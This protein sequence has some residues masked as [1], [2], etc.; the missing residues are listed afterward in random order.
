M[1]TDEDAKLVTLARQARARIQAADGA[2]VRDEMGRS[3]S[4]ATIDL[5]GLQVSALALAV[6]QAAAAGAQSIEAAVVVTSEGAPDAG[7]L[8]HLIAP[9]G[10]L[11]TCSPS[12]EVLRSDV[13][14][15]DGIG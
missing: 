9:G 6:A 12:G 1:L 8:R 5:P 4:G 7:P 13:L 3:Y 14:S 2:A 10:L 15:T 11:H